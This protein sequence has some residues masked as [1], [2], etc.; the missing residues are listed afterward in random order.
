MSG[1]FSKKAGIF[2]GEQRF[3]KFFRPLSAL[4]TAVIISVI[5]A[6][7][8]VSGYH[9][10]EGQKQQAVQRAQDYLNNITSLKAGFAQ[11]GPGSRQGDGIFYYRP[12]ALHMDYAIPHSMVMVAHNEHL[13]L[14]D[15]VNATHTSLSLKHNPLGFLLH[16]PL[17]FS[18]RSMEVTDVHM[19][20]QSLQL[21][22]AQANNPSQG[23][24][25]L[26]FSDIQGKLTL[27]GL[28]GVDARQQHFGLSL[29]DVHEGEKLDPAL[30]V[31]PKAQ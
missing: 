25:T 2:A 10:L 29:F 1:R 21:S 24:L 9:H 26:Q 5:L 8:A 11:D 23:L 31:F 16:V 15:P 22:L 30:F 14:D 13:V 18:A 17:D 7:C 12:G 6:G 19:G 28:Q 4:M 3:R 27:V 20:N